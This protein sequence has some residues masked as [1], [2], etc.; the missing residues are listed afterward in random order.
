MLVMV[1][2]NP[3]SAWESAVDAVRGMLADE[4]VLLLVTPAEDGSVVRGSFGGLMESDGAAQADQA[5]TVFD[6]VEAALGRP[7]RRLW[8]RGRIE[9]EVAGAA[10]GADLLVCVR[11]GDPAR[12][13]PPSLSTR[14]R[15]AI[16]HAPCAVLLVWPGAIGG[17]GVPGTLSQPRPE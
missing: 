3:D 8:L 2:I 7:A 10:A 17:H 5:A 13:G 1:W 14:T 4:I 6:D 12:P 16:D 9:D 15:Y 11:D